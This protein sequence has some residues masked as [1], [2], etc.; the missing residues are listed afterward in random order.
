MLPRIIEF[1]MSLNVGADG[2]A[3]SVRCTVMYLEEARTFL[4][5]ATEVQH[6]ST[7]AWNQDMGHLLL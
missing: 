6:L 3:K 2:A 7:D 1:P 5:I 4:E